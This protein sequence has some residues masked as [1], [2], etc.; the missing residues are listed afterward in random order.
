MK[1]LNKSELLDQLRAHSFVRREVKLA[2]GASSDWFV[3]CKQT[4]LRAAG[5]RA[6][7]EVLLRHVRASFPQCEVVAGVALGGCPLASAVSL[8][9]ALE[10]R[11]LDAFYV[12]RQVK[13]HGSA[14]SI[15][16]D[17]LYKK[18]AKVVV[19][20]DVVTSGGSTLQAVELLRSASHEV[21]GVIALV[22]R[23]AGGRAALEEAGLVFEALFR[24][25]DFLGP[26]PV[27]K[28]A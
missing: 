6:A 25:E 14:R 7:G 1:Q 28:R 27:G 8:C 12:R 24:R 23:E 10:E 4:V 11:P 13:D 17:D 26:S 18:G 3:D 5:H 15:E 16:G 22:D 20:E 21:L 9:S 2:S 19:L